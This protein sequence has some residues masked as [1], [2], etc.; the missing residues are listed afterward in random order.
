MINPAFE[1]PGRKKRFNN[2]RVVT[3]H[4][5]KFDVQVEWSWD[6]TIGGKKTDC[7]P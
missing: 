2:Y 1:L 7:R 6:D 5:L 4:K 3:G